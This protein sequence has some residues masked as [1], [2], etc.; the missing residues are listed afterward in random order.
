M[1]KDFKAIL[2]VIALMWVILVLDYLLPY[3]FVRLGIF[4]RKL[5]GTAGILFAPI[6]HGSFWHLASN[7][8]PFVI[9]NGLLCFF[10]GKLSFKVISF[11]VLVGGLLVWI[12]GRP[13]MHIG[14][15][16]LIYGLA[17][18][19]ITSGFLR[20]KIRALLLSFVI[21]VLYGSM[22]WGVL[23]LNPYV[24]WEGHLFGAISG[25]MA[26]FVYRKVQ[27]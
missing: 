3:D 13:A 12:F 27:V 18:F 9:L 21:I 23:P 8:G 25:V 7:T 24:S 17:A 2:I 14:A 20:K 11:I 16:G 4:P 19:I 10:Y 6:L 22:I 1:R 26:S 5:S 15:S